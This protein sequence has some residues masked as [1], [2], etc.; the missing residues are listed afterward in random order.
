MKVLLLVAHLVVAL[1]VSATVAAA[2]LAASP[3]VENTTPETTRSEALGYGDLDVVLIDFGICCMDDAV[4][5]IHFK[6]PKA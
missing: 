2:Q 1:R 5:S 3:R 6:R 4:L